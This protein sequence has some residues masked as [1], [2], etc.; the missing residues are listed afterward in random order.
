M[1][2]SGTASERKRPPSSSERLR[3]TPP[4]LVRVEPVLRLEATQVAVVRRAPVVVELRGGDRESR[5]CQ[6]S[7]SLRCPAVASAPCCSVRTR[8]RCSQARRIARSGRLG[9][10]GRRWDRAPPGQPRSRT[11]AEADHRDGDA[12][13][14]EGAI[15]SEEREVSTHAGAGA[16][17]S[18]L[19]RFR[20]NAR[21]HTRVRARLGRGCRQR[22]AGRPCAEQVGTGQPG[23]AASAH[24][25]ESSP[26]ATA[27][28][29]LDQQQPMRRSVVKGCARRREVSGATPPDSGNAKCCGTTNEARHSCAPKS[30][31]RSER[32]SLH[33]ERIELFRGSRMGNRESRKTLFKNRS[34]DT[35]GSSRA[36]ASLRL[37]TVQRGPAARSAAPGGASHSL[38]R[39]ACAGSQA[40]C[41]CPCAWLA[42]RWP[43][44]RV[45]RSRRRQ[46][47]QRH[48]RTR[49]RPQTGAH[50]LAACCSPRATR[51]CCSRPSRAPRPRRG[52]RMD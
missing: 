49:G 51:L 16:S 20:R 22:L 45:R 14:P 1:S 29:R 13:A 39:W 35:P 25:C 41:C 50:S 37:Q 5:S 27:A 9:G 40:C 3:P 21:E 24:R 52:T 43:A 15:E 34:R 38:R 31:R 48:S 12:A 4:R 28:S 23:W 8:D 44:L 19:L 42:S 6:R 10:G 7:A 2:D 46:R 26:A 30:G 33:E 47:L 17:A 36:V 18:A 32:V 11:V